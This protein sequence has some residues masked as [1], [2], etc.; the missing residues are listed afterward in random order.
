MLHCILHTSTILLNT[1]CSA[2]IS[3]CSILYQAGRAN[4]RPTIDAVCQ[5]V[6][7]ALFV[8]CLKLCIRFYTYQNP[9]TWLF[10]FLWVLHLFYQT[11]LVMTTTTRTHL[12]ALHPI[13]SRWVSTII[14]LL[15]TQSHFITSF[16]LFLYFL[17]Y[18]IFNLLSAFSMDR[19]IFFA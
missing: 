12:M 15:L 9:K 17:L 16:L 18:N 6:N 5:T 19:N 4:V 2:T 1:L 10:T 13:W 11:L 3:D 7:F 8:W 14:H